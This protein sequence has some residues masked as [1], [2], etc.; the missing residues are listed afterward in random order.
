M[1]ITIYSEPADQGV[2]L[3]ETA[4]FSVGAESN[5]ELKFHWSWNN[6]DGWQPIDDTHPNPAFSDF[7]TE[8]LK[9]KTG[10]GFGH[11]L[12]GLLRGWLGLLGQG[13]ERL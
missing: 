10:T 3:G 13:L 1:P 8:S 7:K 11:A 2:N 12:G 6:G 5:T 4:I 9:V